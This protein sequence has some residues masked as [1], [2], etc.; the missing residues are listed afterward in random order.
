M[1]DIDN[2]LSVLAAELA[3]EEQISSRVTDRTWPLY[4]VTLQAGTRSL[5]DTLGRMS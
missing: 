4:Q 5:L 1:E 2:S 3:D